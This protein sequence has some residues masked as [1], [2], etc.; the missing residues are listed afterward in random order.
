M[1]N[2]CETGVIGGIFCG[3]F[4][5]LCSSIL[6]LFIL[7]ESHKHYKNKQNQIEGFVL[8]VEF[9]KENKSKIIFKDGRIKEFDGVIPK[10]IEK[11]K[12]Y[13]IIYNGY[14]YIVDLKEKP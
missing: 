6:F 8:N 4:V 1:K 14:N 3:M 13:I 12:Y 11:G 9:Y 10:P 5:L 2:D 7:D